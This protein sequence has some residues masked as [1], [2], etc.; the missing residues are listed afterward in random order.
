M[1]LEDVKEA[2]A[3]SVSTT[4]F[5]QKGVDSIDHSIRL[6]TYYFIL[7]VFLG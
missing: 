6:S 1:S 7:S 2:D 4:P 3:L 5:S